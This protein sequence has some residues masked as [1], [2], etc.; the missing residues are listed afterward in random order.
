MYEAKP[1]AQLPKKIPGQHR[2]VATAAWVISEPT[3]VAAFDPGELKFLDR[4]NLMSLMM[5]CWDCERELGTEI[6]PGSRCPA[7]AVD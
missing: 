4:E 5:G 1:H 3:V 2:W 7:P 6:K